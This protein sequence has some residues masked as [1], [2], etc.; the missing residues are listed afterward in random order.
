MK[1]NRGGAPRG[2]RPGGSRQGARSRLEELV[3][4]VINTDMAAL[5]FSPEMRTLAYRVLQF[6]ARG[7][8]VVILGGGTGLSTV[9]GGN[10]QRADWARM[11]FVG[12]KEEFPRL[13]VVVCTTDDGG[14]TG[15]LLKTM[16]MIAIGD[17][18]KSA[19][20]LILAEN[21]QRAYRLPREETYGLVHCIQRIFN[22]RFA[23]RP[24]DAHR[25]ADPLLV[26]PARQRAAI[27]RKLAERLRGLGAYVAAG[28]KGPRIDPAGH[29]LGNLL[30][31]SAIFREAGG[32]VDRP[33]RLLEIQRGLDAVSRLIGAT[34]GS[35]FPATATPGQLRF[36]YAN[37][38]EVLGQCKSA[39][40]RRNFPVERLAAGFCGTP[41]VSG[42]VLQSLRE[43]EMI[44]LDRKSVV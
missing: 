33:P 25:P 43:A 20:S 28:G 7:T 24:A 31:T 41:V 32:R 15:R 27:P 4:A 22:H 44:I 23:E 34:P 38:V 2:P 5:R 26:L 35:L 19:L 30:L 12:L 17:L 29:C 42:R 14:S 9:V 13:K 37:G 21:L 18:R 6:D 40:A 11:P 10:A 16:P 3:E 36:R 39:S 8:G 1:K